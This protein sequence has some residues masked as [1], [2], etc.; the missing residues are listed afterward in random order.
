MVNRNVVAAIPAYNMAE[1]LEGLLRQI[2]S[3][4]YDDVVVIDDASTDDTPYV[5]RRGGAELIRNRHNQGAGASR[6][7][8]LE[9]V[10]DPDVVI[11]FLDADVELKQPSTSNIL[12]RMPLDE[13]TSLVGGLA[14]TR[15]GIQNPFNYG[16]RQT[17]RGS[18]TAAI[19]MKIAALVENGKVE[20]AQKLR[21]RF[22]HKLVD[23]P[24]MAKEPEPR[25]VF[26]AIEQN[27]V[28]RQGTFAKLQGFDPRLREHEIQD[29]AIRAAKRGLKAYFDPSFATQHQE[30]NVRPGLRGLHQLAAELRIAKWHSFGKWLTS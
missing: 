29:F 17:L 16:P 4:G 6:N 14:L 20:E 21:A 9:Y 2:W 25:E 28:M 1:P 15:S 12:R 7:R 11:H 10:R 27:I 8:V 24:D 18:L 30:I 5:A 19:Q 3:G 22:E 23:W 13:E 26:W